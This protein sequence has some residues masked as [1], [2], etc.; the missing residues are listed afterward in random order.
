MYLF[1]TVSY[2]PTHKPTRRT[3]AAKEKVKATTVHSHA[4]IVELRNTLSKNLLKLRQSQR[5]YMPG[6]Q[7]LLE[8][9]E[10]SGELKLWL[11]SELSQSDRAA[12][13]LEGISELEFRFR[14]AQADDSLAETRRL[15]RL[16]QGLLD[17]KA[18]HPS[19]SQRYSNRS[20]TVFATFQTRINR[21][22]KRYRHARCAM[23]ALD[24]CEKVSPGWPKRFQVL[25][26][27]DVRG[28][29][30]SPEESEGKYQPSWIWL[31]AMQTNHGTD[32]SP[33]E[34]GPS[35]ATDPSTHLDNPEVADAMRVHWAKCQARA[36]RYEEEVQLTVE[37]MGR[38]LQYFKW[39]QAQWLSL[40]SN[41]AKS[42]PP[43]P[44]E[45]QRGLRAYARRQAHVY[46][47][48]TI[49]FANRWRKFLVQHD[50]GS[51]WLCDYPIATDPL[52]VRPSRGHRPPG[53]KLDPTPAGG[54][55]TGAASSLP[56]P[57]LVNN[58]TDSP[59]ESESES[60]AEN[61]YVI[62]EGEEFDLED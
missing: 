23:L 24:P 21:A 30:R 52:S 54:S 60:G 35:T 38:T 10:N 62:G 46:K 13:C 36:D 15:R 56:V 59:L 33:D 18:K 1:L 45:V 47:T 16:V 6:V 27:A 12:W 41:R 5:I 55:S 28:P 29:G 9:D 51:G 19:Q 44:I 22:T 2:P 39:K 53:A 20:Q 34:P 42:T 11:P 7:P 48:L 50:L 32:P 3:L 31:V 14:Y 58:A 8:D 37:E 4:V 40:Q 57:S 26:D 25:E 17:Q 49:S 61:E 43:P